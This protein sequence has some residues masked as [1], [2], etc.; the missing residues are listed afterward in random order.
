MPVHTYPWKRFWYPREAP[1]ELRDGGYLYRPNAEW[2]DRFFGV[3]GILLEK[4]A[5]IPCLILLGEPGQGKSQEL[6]E[7]QT[8]TRDHLSEAVLWCDFNAYQEQA[9]LY[10]ALFDNATFQDWLHGIHRL[11]LFLDSLDEGLLSIRTLARFL[12]VE[13]ARYRDSLSR[14]SLRITCRVAEW[15]N[16]F[17]EQL[18]ELWSHANVQ[19]FRLAPLRREDVL[20]AA[21]ANGLD[22][23]L[24]LGEVD[25][26]AAVPLANRPITLRF[27]L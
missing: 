7:Q 5:S 11:H 8:F 13:L 27:L 26:K 12:S 2:A 6:R 21:R 16:T 1:I 14:L 25:R 20:E 23:D 3:N 24:F 19:V 17:E 10:R 9:M 15:P 18:L 22:A 4:L